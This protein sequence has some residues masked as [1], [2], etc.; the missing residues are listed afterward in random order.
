MLYE[1]A[2]ELHLFL[3]VLHDHLG[4]I[5]LAAQAV[6][7]H[8]HGQVIRVHLGDGHV[9]GGGEDFQKPNQIG[10]HEAIE[11][12]QSL[13]YSHASFGLCAALNALVVEFVRY[14]R[15]VEL[16]VPEFEKRCGQMRI[17]DVRQQV[18]ASVRLKH[19]VRAPEMIES[20]F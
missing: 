8:N 10:E 15:L 7:R 17:S 14:E 16:S 12:G 13:D 11:L 20:H 19:L 4:L 2:N 5:G 3:G 1:R 6:G 18:L 9:L